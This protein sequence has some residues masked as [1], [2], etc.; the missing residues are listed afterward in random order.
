MT[1]STPMSRPRGVT[2]EDFPGSMLTDG[3]IAWLPG[4]LGVLG[5]AAILGAPPLLGYVAISVAWVFLGL[6][7]RANPVARRTG[8]RAAIVGGLHLLLLA[9]VLGVQSALIG[10]SVETAEPYD[11]LLVFPGT[12]C[13]VLVSPLVGIALGT[14]ALIAP[15]SRARAQR[16]LVRR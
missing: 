11:V 16:V 2:P 15:V 8:R 9:V 3:R 10:A 13:I 6:L 1:T 7:Q 14:M 12:V 5:V 4:F